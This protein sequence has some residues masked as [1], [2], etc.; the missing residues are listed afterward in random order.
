MFI[1]LKQI[2]SAVGT[3][4]KKK[5]KMIKGSGKCYVTYGNAYKENKRVKAEHSFAHLLFFFTLSSAFGLDFEF[6]SGLMLGLELRLEFELGLRLG[7]ARI[8]IFLFFH[9]VTT[10]F[11]MSTYFVTKYCTFYFVTKYCT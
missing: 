2:I 7:L 6:G 5:K 8:A 3:E 1:C 10:I 11:A 4:I 9:N